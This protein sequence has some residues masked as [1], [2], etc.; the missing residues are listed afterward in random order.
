MAAEPDHSIR[1]TK[2][3]NRCAFPDCKKKCAL[4]IGNCR[5]CE[6]KFCESHRLPEVHQCSNIQECRDRHFI[7]NQDKLLSEKCV[8]A[9]VPAA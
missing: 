5:Y 4:L 8:A 3:K 6:S 1:V 2:K 9:K 7:R